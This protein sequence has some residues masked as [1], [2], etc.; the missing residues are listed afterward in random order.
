MRLIFILP[1]S[2]AALAYI[3]KVCWT[4]NV[5]TSERLCRYISGAIAV[6]ARERSERFDGP[7]PP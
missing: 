1:V 5:Y 4:P 6:T 3:L 2:P 7:T